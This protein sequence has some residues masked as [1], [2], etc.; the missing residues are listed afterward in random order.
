M[1]KEVKQSKN[2]YEKEIAQFRAGKLWLEERII[3]AR[4]EEIAM[5]VYKMTP[6]PVKELYDEI[7][8]N[9]AGKTAKKIQCS[10]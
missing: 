10:I 9:A 4:K 5:N 1:I 8:T 2:Q 3:L 7:W 6:F